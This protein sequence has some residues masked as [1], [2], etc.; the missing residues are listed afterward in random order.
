MIKL[1][2]YRYILLLILLLNFP[3]FGFSQT[4]ESTEKVNNVRMVVTV[5]N[6]GMSLIPTFSLGK[7]AIVF[8]ASIGRR[9]TFDPMI[10]YS[11]EG[12]PW[13]FIFWWRYKLIKPSKFQMTLGA[14]PSVMFKT[15]NGTIN[16]VQTEIIR[17]RQYVVGE[18]YPYYTL[19]NHISVGLYYNY[20]RGFATDDTKNLHFLTARTIL[21]NISLSRNLVLSVVPQLYYLKMDQRDGFYVTSAFTLSKRNFPF[22]VSSVVNKTIKSDIV[23]DDFVWNLSLNYTFLKRYVER[24]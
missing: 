10:R 7:P 13:S 22:S 23:S 6:N 2:P 3:E 12:K 20:S 11:L 4:S 16:G 5:T 17:G 14:H 24:K 15:V 18:L 8:D 21:S 19:S 9:L 1:I